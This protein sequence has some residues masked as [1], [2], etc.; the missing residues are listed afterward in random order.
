MNKPSAGMLA[1]AWVEM[2]GEA[3]GEPKDIAKRFMV[4]Q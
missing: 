2:Q 1:Y 4:L 3:I